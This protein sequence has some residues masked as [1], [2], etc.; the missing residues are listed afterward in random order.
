MCAHR[1]GPEAYIADPA[2]VV[3]DDLNAFLDCSFE[4]AQRIESFDL[5]PCCK[6]RSAG[7]SA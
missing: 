2:A 4:R 6:W 3:L 5:N 7:V 1:E